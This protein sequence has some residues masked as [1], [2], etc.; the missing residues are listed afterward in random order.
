MT[1]RSPGSASWERCFASNAM[2]AGQ[3]LYDVT[4]RDRDPP[5]NRTA[6]CRPSIRAILTSCGCSPSIPAT[7]SAEEDCAAIGRFRKSGRGL[8]VTR[9]HMD[10]GSSV[11]TLGGIG[12]A[13][14]FHSIQPG[15][16]RRQA[17]AGRSLYDQHRLAE[18]PF[19]SEWRFPAHRDRRAGPSGA[20]QSGRADRR[21]FAICRPIRMKA[22]LARPTARR[23]G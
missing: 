16:R 12:D 19:R 9:D 2:R 18:F 6:C 13:H 10:L 4:M 22:A 20:G 17:T 1:G 3:P 8:L 7:G 5:G 14:Y 15:S 23:R 11:C 21:S